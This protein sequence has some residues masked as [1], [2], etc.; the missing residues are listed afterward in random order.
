[1]SNLDIEKFRKVHSL[2]NGGATA[3]ERA[4]AKARAEAMAAKAGMT[5][6]Q[7]AS[8]LDAVSEPEPKGFFDGF[9]DWMEA[10]EPGYKARRSSE[11]EAR[12]NAKAIRRRVLLAKYGSEAA[13]F[14]RTDREA[15]LLTAVSDVA[16]IRDWMGEDGVVYTYVDCIEGKR[17]FWRRSDMSDLVYDRIAGAYPVPEIL[18]E[19]MEEYRAWESLRDDRQAFCDAEWNHHLEVD[20]RIAVLVDALETRPVSSWEDIAA[21]MDWWDECLRSDI[22]ASREEQQARKDRLAGD[23]KILRKL[24]CASAQG[25]GSAV[26]RNFSRRTNSEIRGAVLSMLDSNPAMSDREIA[27][28]IGVS[29]QTVCNWRKRT[30]NVARRQAV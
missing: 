14:A 9:E 21:R 13:V 5:L 25:D 16:D 29:H 10:R 4:A 7:A 27:R 26:A 11:R 1:M 30:G 20:A 19:I 8:N 17:D 6:K 22:R 18:A 15:M 2:I 28:R 12:N 23:L 24:G 3:G